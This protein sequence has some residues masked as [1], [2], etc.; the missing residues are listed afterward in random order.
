LR[1]SVRQQLRLHIDDGHRL[2]VL[3]LQSAERR[4]GQDILGY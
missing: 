1:H 2:A 3:I 4:L